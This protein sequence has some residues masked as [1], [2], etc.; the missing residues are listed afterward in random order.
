MKIMTQTKDIENRIYFI[1]EQ[2][3]M[4]D[5]DLAEL[6]GVKPKNLN[7]AVK[8]NRI[9]FPE[10]FMFQLDKSEVQSLRF[11]SGTLKRGQ[12][13]K[14]LPYAFSQEGIAMLSSVLRSQ[15]AALVNISIM[16]AFVR[17]RN[18]LASN[19]DLARRVAKLEKRTDL[20]DMDIRLLIQDVRKL[21]I[22]P[23]PDADMDPI[24]IKGF[25]KGG[26]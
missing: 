16:R 15:R 4:L 26:A 24:K 5:R 10:D 18:I 22:G 1:R 7:K 17:L 8:R 11:Q 12:H 20:H 23:G 19:K 25:G 21:L 3:V 13:S 14:Y 2:K 6:Y 9:R